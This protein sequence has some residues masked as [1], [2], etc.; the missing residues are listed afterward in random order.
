MYKIEKTDYGYK[1]T[2]GD[3]ISKDEMAKWVEES[4]T[5]LMSAPAQFGIFVDMRTLQ[6]LSPE[7]Q[8]VMTQGQK[9]YKEKGMQRSVVILNDPTVTMQFMRLGKQSGIYQWERY[10]DASTH[11]DFEA[12]GIAWLKDGTDPDA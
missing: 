9:L 5:A 7:V 4:K 8:E 11:S 2:F 6:P 1:L 3:A 10:I 12:K